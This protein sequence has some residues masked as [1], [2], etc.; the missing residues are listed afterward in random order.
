MNNYNT[1]FNNEPIAPDASMSAIAGPCR[2]D[3]VTVAGWYISIDGA[4]PRSANT[5]GL[6]QFDPSDIDHPWRSQTGCAD[7]GPFDPDEILVG[8]IFFKK[9]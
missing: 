1:T 4:D 8:P 2:F 7:C 3:S 9:T 5:N 6:Y